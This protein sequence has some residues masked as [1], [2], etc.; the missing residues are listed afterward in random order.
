MMLFLILTV[1][2]SK[3]WNKSFDPWTLKQRQLS[4]H[5]CIV[6]SKNPRWTTLRQLLREHPLEHSTQPLVEHITQPLVKNIWALESALEIGVHGHWNHPSRILHSKSLYF[7]EYLSVWCRVRKTSR[8]YSL[9]D[10]HFW[11]NWL[12]DPC[13]PAFRSSWPRR[14]FSLAFAQNLPWRWLR[15]EPLLEPVFGDHS[16]VSVLPD[17]PP[18][19]GD[20][21]EKSV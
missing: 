11:M 5:V 3:T 19:Q 15:V 16:H 18:G 13:I 21:C 8:L 6:D 17:T 2:R 1:S 4:F 14:V 7:K 12:N 9:N 20:W 10:Q